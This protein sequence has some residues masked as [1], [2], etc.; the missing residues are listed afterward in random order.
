MNPQSRAPE[1]SFAD[2]VE[3]APSELVRGERP[4]KLRLDHNGTPK[5]YLGLYGSGWCI[6]SSDGLVFDAYTHEK[7][8]TYFRVTQGDWKDHYLSV[9]NSAYLGLYIWS[10]AVGWDIEA[11]DG[12][13]RLRCLWNHQVA[14]FH[15]DENQYV[16]AWD[17]YH[18]LEVHKEHV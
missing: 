14:S 15:S 5:G 7:K 2:S 13:K 18:K 16:Y 17:D 11:V 9:N 8:K 6:L 4:F 10:N 1:G 3:L 12:Q